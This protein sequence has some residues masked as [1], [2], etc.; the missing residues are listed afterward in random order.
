MG[1]ILL[2]SKTFNG[3]GCQ[4]DCSAEGV[5]Q[6]NLIASVKTSL[7]QNGWSPVSWPTEPSFYT[8]YLY[9]KNGHPLILQVGTRDAVTGGMYVDIEFQ[10]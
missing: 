5:A 7:S 1:K 2:L 3:N 10:Y 6:N 4:S 9:I 8:D